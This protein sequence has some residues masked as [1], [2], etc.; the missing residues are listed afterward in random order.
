MPRADPHAGMVRPRDPAH[1]LTDLLGLHADRFAK[2]SCPPSG[3]PE[4]GD[5]LTLHGIRV[6]GKTVSLGF[7][8]RSSGIRAEV[9]AQETS[10]GVVLGWLSA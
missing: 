1:G 8:R 3:L 10:P 9:I 7:S 2:P 6:I 5:T 4:D